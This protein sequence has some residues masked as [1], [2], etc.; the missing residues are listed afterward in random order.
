MRVGQ[1]DITPDDC[2]LLEIARVPEELR[3]PESKLMQSR[4][5]DYRHL[6]PGQA[7]QLFADRFEAIYTEMYAKLRD[8][9]TAESVRIFTTEIF[10]SPDLIPCWTARQAADEIGCDYDFYIRFTLARAWDRG[11]RYIPRPNQL[12]NEA[13]T[14]DMKET[15]ESQSRFVLK[16][17]QHERFKLDAY[18]GHPDQDAYHAYLIRQVTQ[19][20]QKHMVLGRL[21][22]KE[23]CL[24]EELAVQ[25][26]GNDLVRK[27][28]AFYR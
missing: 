26:F 2:W 25:H 23:R 14:T 8:Y 10:S 16:L 1:K 3:E 7:T 4:W 18:E 12:Y 24:P 19:R 22:H 6:L 11:W 20:E 15:W 9:R 27:A 28:I 5:F 21:L 17:A 13:L